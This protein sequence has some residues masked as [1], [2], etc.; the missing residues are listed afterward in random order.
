MGTTPGALF[1]AFVTLTKTMSAA[2]KHQTEVDYT[3]ENLADVTAADVELKKY[4]KAAAGDDDN[5]TA[6][7]LSKATGFSHRVSERMIAEYLDDQG[8]YQI[9][10]DTFFDNYIKGADQDHNGQLSESEKNR[11]LY[12]PSYYSLS[13]PEDN[14]QKMI[15]LS[16]NQ[17][18]AADIGFGDDVTVNDDTE[19]TRAEAIADATTYLTEAAN[20][21]GDNTK[22]TVAEFSRSTG[23]SQG[24]VKFLTQHYKDNG[25]LDL[26]QP[27]DAAKVIAAL[28]A[29]DGQD[30]IIGADRK[31]VYE[32]K[33]ANAGFADTYATAE[34]TPPASGGLL[35]GLGGLLKPIADGL[36]L[37]G[38]GGNGGGLNLGKIGLLVGGFFL[39][40]SLFKKP[41]V[42]PYP[43]R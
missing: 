6:T 23:L 20:I 7:E 4:F 41:E 1:N 18:Q 21:D 12:V 14:A 30:G 34:D 10:P 33:A 28:D 13:K 15:G 3:K 31:E 8:S 27:A 29:I 26:T 16:K 39:V 35:G 5:L 22:L 36:G 43:Y 37:G 40:K 2:K 24:A 19:Y 32:Q 11:L 25:G 38:N 42:N 9:D 17:R